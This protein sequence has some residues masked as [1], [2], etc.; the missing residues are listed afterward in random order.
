MTLEPRTR[1]GAAL[2]VDVEGEFSV[3]EGGA[4]RWVSRSGLV[5]FFDGLAAVATAELS[6]AFVNTASI[7]ELTDGG[8]LAPLVAA[9]RQG[10]ER[11]GVWARDVT[12][13]MPMERNPV[14][15]AVRNRE[16]VDLARPTRAKVLVVGWDGADWMLIRPLLAAG[17]MPNLAGLIARGRATELRSEQPLLSPLLWTTIAT[18]KPVLEH[19]IADFLV[20]DAATGARVPITSASRKVHALWTILPAFGLKVDTVAWWATWPAEPT[21]GTLVSDRVAYQLFDLE[22]TT[23]AGKVYPSGSWPAVRERIHEPEQVPCDLMRRFVALG[24]DELDRRWREAPPD[25]RQED[26][27]N[28]LRKILATTRTYHS[29]TLDLL[30]SQADLT[31]TYYEATDTIGHLFA[32]YLP[33]KLP[34]VTDEEVDTFGGALPEAYVYLDELLGELLDQVDP[35]TNVLVI[36]DHGF[37]VG[38][39]RPRTDTKDFGAGASNWHRL[40]G[41]LVA[42]GPRGARGGYEG[43]TIY[44]I[45]PTILGWLGL[46]VPTDMKGRVLPDEPGSRRLDTYERLIRAHAREEVA[47]DREADAR[48]IKELV[49]LGYLSPS[50]ALADPP[51]NRESGEVAPATATAPVPP[52]VV[53]ES[54][55]L[56]TEAYNRGRIHQRRGEYEEAEREFRTAI[57]RQPGFGQGWASLAQVASLRGDHVRAFRI[58]EEGLGV[59]RDMPPS[60]LTGLVDEARDAGI[61]PQAEAALKRLAATPYRTRSAFH[62]AWGLFFEATDRRDRALG[63]YRNALEI[64]PL[65]Q[66][67]VERLVS[68]LRSKGDVRSAVELFDATL[69]HARGSM[70]AVNHLGLVSLREGMPDRAEKI[71]RQLLESDP[72]NA[73]LLSN[74]AL[75]LSRQGRRGEAIDMMKGAVAQEPSNAQN[76]FNLG[77]L[78]V[79][80]SR[81]DQ[82]LREFEAAEK[83][84]LKTPTVYV[85]IAKMRFRSGDPGGAESALRQALRIDPRHQE[86]RELLAALGGEP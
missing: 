32:R 82:A 21:S 27:V 11:S 13:R 86:S 76:H 48:R 80:E 56:A 37:Y 66:L 62:S 6:S 1:E 7:E 85:A 19:G 64:D 68:L 71:F 4:Q 17:R 9:L 35:E 45:A 84:G 73:G 81:I 8:D 44:D 23:D 25:K 15:V 41:I 36:S 74:L 77:A 31:L 3:A 59:S 12:L 70:S 16:I 72:R 50:A 22:Q 46:P 75:A 61:L 34:G 40:D 78:L 33:P 20:Q 52:P 29:V 28:H 49:A 2:S 63:A 53:T 54:V 58:L 10:L 69:E 83:Y 67:A 18:G 39:A 5:P 60:A 42:A 38:E 47:A 30:K 65:D 26:R 51:G 24:C 57:D 79:E 55:G 43:A 14:L